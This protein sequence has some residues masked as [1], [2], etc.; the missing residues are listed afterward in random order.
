MSQKTTDWG[1]ER[2]SK[3]NELWMLE[4][5]KKIVEKLVVFDAKIDEERKKHASK[6]TVFFASVL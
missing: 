6:N 1:G 3:I 4:R 2:A 5:E